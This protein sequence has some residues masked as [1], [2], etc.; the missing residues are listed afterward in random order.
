MGGG[1]WWEGCKWEV[2]WEWELEGAGEKEG[3][4]EKPLDESHLGSHDGT[5][6]DLFGHGSRHLFRLQL[7]LSSILNRALALF[8][9]LQ[10]K[11]MQAKQNTCR[12]THAGKTHAHGENGECRNVAVGGRKGDGRE[13]LEQEERS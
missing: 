11:R 7:Q 4:G 13:E 1:W 3:R 8:A 5:L 6:L 2:G 9:Q 10:S 12:Q